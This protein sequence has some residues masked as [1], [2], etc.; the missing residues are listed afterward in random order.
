MEE[1]LKSSGSWTSLGHLIE[2][3][4]RTAFAQHTEEDKNNKIRYHF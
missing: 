1:T 2:A 3:F 4:F